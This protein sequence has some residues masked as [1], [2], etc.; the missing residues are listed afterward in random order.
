MI[1]PSGIIF[2][3]VF[4][5][6]NM[7]P[8]FPVYNG[9]WTRASCS[10]LQLRLHH[11]STNSQVRVC[12][13]RIS[14]R[15]GPR[16]R[17]GPKQRAPGL[18]PSTADLITQSDIGE[19]RRAGSGRQNVYC[20]DVVATR[21]LA[22][23]LGTSTGLVSHRTARHGVA[24]MRRRTRC[25]LPDWSA[26]LDVLSSYRGRTRCWIN[27]LC[28]LSECSTHDIR[29]KLLVLWTVARRTN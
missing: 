16:G 15:R 20:V 29:L 27:S 23:T 13:H 8:H 3:I 1:Y 6:T 10:L 22:R 26:I 18:R 14:W 24:R 19:A 2:T 21:A 9:I 17:S 12:V 7:Y 11:R 5:G 4:T 28:I 25:P